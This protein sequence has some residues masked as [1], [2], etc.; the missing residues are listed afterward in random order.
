MT[1][2]FPAPPPG[3]SPW[4]SDPPAGQKERFAITEYHF[5]GLCSKCTNINTKFQA[6]YIVPEKIEKK[7][8]NNLFL[9][10]NLINKKICLYSSRNLNKTGL[11]EKEAL[12]MS[13]GIKQRKLPFE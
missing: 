5:T 4:C 13:E 8:G 7:V 10:R 9:V 6:K 2:G 1:D 11:N 12:E 3:T